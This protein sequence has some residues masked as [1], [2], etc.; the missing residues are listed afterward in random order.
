MER[1][2]REKVK[3][4]SLDDGYDPEKCKQNTAKLAEAEKVFLL[5]GHVGTPTAK[6]SLQLVDQH[7]IPF[8]PQ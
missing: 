8:L 3:L 6:A 5:F 1:N 2:K 7:K 4:I